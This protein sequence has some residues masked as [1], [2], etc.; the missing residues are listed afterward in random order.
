MT[1]GP[2]NPVYAIF[3]GMI[4]QDGLNRLTQGIGVALNQINASA[5]HLMLQ[6]GGGGVGEGICLYNIFKSVPVPLTLYNS[7]QLCSIAAVAYLGAPLRCASAR[8]SF[9]YHPVHFSPQAAPSE[10]LQR[11]AE[12]AAMDDARIDSILKEHLSLSKRQWET[13][14]RADLWL[15]AEEAVKVGVATE[16]AEFA[17]PPGRRIFFP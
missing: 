2:D 14:S 13:H 3:V 15:S 8:A 17:P 10:S 1:D 6:S 12:V 11:F 7:G 16:I 4:D 9:M 5:I